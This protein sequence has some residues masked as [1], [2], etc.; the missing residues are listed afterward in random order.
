MSHVSFDG[1]MHLNSALINDASVSIFVLH[2]L[3]V[4][5]TYTTSRSM[6]LLVYHTKQLHTVIHVL[7]VG[8]SSFITEVDSINFCSG[9]VIS[10][11]VA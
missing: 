8:A 1:L 9:T 4:S 5:V 7:S 2:P 10:V 6:G 3:R 11:E